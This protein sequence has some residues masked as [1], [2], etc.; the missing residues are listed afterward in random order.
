MLNNYAEEVEVERSYFS[1]MESIEELL[2]Q[3]ERKV[4]PFSTLN[5]N[6]AGGTPM[7]VMSAVNERLTIIRE[8]LSE[9]VQSIE[10]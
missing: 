6:K 4:R 7:P 10:E 1:K 2:N 9:I 5:T 8:R 3:L